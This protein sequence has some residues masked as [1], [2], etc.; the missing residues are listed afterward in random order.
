MNITIPAAA[1]EAGALG[2]FR[3]R[4]E[5]DPVSPDDDRQMELGRM[6]ARAACLAMLTAWPGMED[7]WPGMLILPLPTEASDDQ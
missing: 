3:E 2:M 4:Y 7:E 1:T 5:R 6:Y